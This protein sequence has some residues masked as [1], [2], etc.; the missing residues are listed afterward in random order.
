MY[1][2]RDEIGVVLSIKTLGFRI[3]HYLQHFSG[4]PRTTKIELRLIVDRQVCCDKITSTAAV[5]SFNGNLCFDHLATA[6]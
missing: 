2:C 6:S 1:V 3:R 4:T 5:I